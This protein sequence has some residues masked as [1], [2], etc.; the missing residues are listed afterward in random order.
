MPNVTVATC[1]AMV[2]AASKCSSPTQPL[3]AEPK[4]ANFDSIA[5]SISSLGAA[6]G[7][8]SAVIVVIALLVAILTIVIGISWGRLV[9]HEAKAQADEAVSVK[10]NELMKIWLNEQA[11]VIVRTHVELILAQT[12][13]TQAADVAADEMGENA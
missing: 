2:S 13:A 1:A 9:A 4:P 12:P 3:I 5:T 6:I 8:G 7:F 11:P 10:V